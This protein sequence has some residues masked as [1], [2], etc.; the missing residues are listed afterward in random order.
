MDRLREEREEIEGLCDFFFFF[1]FF[2]LTL[3]AETPS[4]LTSHLLRFTC[5][6]FLSGAP[7]IL[8]AVIAAFAGCIVIH[9]PP[10]REQMAF[11]F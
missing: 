5:S 10:P 11:K 3:R 4:Q 9:A 7:D 6:V 2:L 8:A 1:S